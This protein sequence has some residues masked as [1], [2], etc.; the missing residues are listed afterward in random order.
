MKE[1]IFLSKEQPFAI[2][3]W[4]SKIYGFHS[5]M[6]SG[7]LY[8]ALKTIKSKLGVVGWLIVF[9]SNRQRGHIETAPSFTVP[10]EGREARFYTVLTG[11]RTPGRCVA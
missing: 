11:N 8:E 4:V 5:S 2:L 10:C 3:N 6:V 7:G 1:I 9:T